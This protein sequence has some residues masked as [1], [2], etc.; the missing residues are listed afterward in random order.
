MLLTLMIVAAV[1]IPAVVSASSS[2]GKAYSE[3]AVIEN[4]LLKTS[5]RIDSLQ[6]SAAVNSV[7]TMSLSNTGSTKLY[8]FD[9]FNVII[10]YDSAYNSTTRGPV[11]TE[12]LRYGGITAS[13]PAVGQWNVEGITPDSLDP[14]IW[15]PG[16]QMTVSAGLSK[17]MFAGGALSA[18]I[19]TDAGEVTT[20]SGMIT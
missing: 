14:Q 20:M 2:M 9:K 10:T 15:N 16:E 5:L 18:I 3:K 19:S 1:A 4:Q 8:N 13:P 12:V 17:E 7:V 6:T 11:E